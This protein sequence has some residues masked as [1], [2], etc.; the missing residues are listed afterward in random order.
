MVASS[1]VRRR[2]FNPRS[3]ME[4]LR[5]TRSVAVTLVVTAICTLAID[6]IWGIAIGIV[7]HFAFTLR[8]K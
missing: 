2:W 5:T 8:R 6:L 4:S 3:I 1:G 7:V